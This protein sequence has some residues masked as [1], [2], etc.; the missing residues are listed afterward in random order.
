[1]TMPGE[2]LKEWAVIRELP[3]AGS[4]AFLLRKDDIYEHAGIFHHRGVGSCRH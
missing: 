3:T 1:M 4:E 2:A